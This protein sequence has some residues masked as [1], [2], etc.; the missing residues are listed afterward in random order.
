M[1]S[2]SL[3]SYEDTGEIRTQHFDLETGGDTFLVTDLVN[4]QE[5]NYLKSLIDKSTMSDISF[6]EKGRI[7]HTSLHVFD[8]PVGERKYSLRAEPSVTN[9][10]RRIVKE[11]GRVLSD[12]FNQ[13]YIAM[14]N[15]R[16]TDSSFSLMM[17]VK[18]E[19]TKM[20]GTHKFVFT[21]KGDELQASPTRFLV[22]QNSSVLEFQ[23]VIVL[24]ENYVTEEKNGRPTYWK[25]VTI[26]GETQIFPAQ[27]I[28]G[29]NFRAI[30][31]LKMY[32]DVLNIFTDSVSEDLFE[33]EE[34]V[35]SPY[36]RKPKV[37]RAYI[38]LQ[39]NVKGSTQ[40]VYLS[41][42]TKVLRGEKSLYLE[43]SFP[44]KIFLRLF[45]EFYSLKTKAEQLELYYRLSTE[46]SLL[47]IS[48]FEYK[49]FNYYFDF[50]FFAGLDTSRPEFP[51]LQITLEMEGAAKGGF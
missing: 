15:I 9:I 2:M 11:R 17:N 48:L 30:A 44:F 50:D 46:K 45:R 12:H 25:L 34:S 33:K 1:L 8:T 41:E 24:D 22:P 27:S 40:S 51:G 42:V 31:F 39:S 43:K 21:E 18:D 29:G 47:A 20:W 23:E 10:I 38:K 37:Q 28:T 16:E 36:Q 4:P 49:A 35:Q 14:H 32:H 3:F 19:E 26:D 13:P 5:T 6:D 7:G